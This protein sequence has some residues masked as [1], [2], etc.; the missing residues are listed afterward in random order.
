M[1]ISEVKRVIKTKMPVIYD[2]IEYERVLN[3][4]LWFDE[5]QGGFRYSLKLQDKNSKISVTKAPMEKVRIK[6]QK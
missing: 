2:G 4:V 1:D 3:C 5:H 6:E